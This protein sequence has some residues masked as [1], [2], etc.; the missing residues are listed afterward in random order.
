MVTTLNVSHIAAAAAKNV[1]PRENW[2][3]DA[4]MAA[5]RNSGFTCVK[6]EDKLHENVTFQVIYATAVK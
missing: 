3:P 5:L 6:M 2:H 4:Y 1:L